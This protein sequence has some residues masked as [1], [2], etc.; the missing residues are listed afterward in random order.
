MKRGHL[1]QRLSDGKFL[2]AHCAAFTIWRSDRQSAIPYATRE[3]AE[4]IVEAGF[5]GH[6]GR[7]PKVHVVPA[8]TSNGGLALAVETQ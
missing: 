4:A 7:P 5:P 3:D 6:V 2:S 1:V 8:D